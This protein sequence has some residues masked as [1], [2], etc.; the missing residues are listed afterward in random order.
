MKNLFTS[1]LLIAVLASCTKK[2]DVNLNICGAANP[3]QE[4]P[5]LA[6]FTTKMQNGDLGDCRRC[7]MYAEK[8]QN[9]DVLV[10]LNFPDN[11]VLCEV[12]ECNGTYS[13]FEN[14]E[15]LNQFMNKM[16]KERLVWK[17]KP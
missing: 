9:R 7:I 11:C 13:K 2:E 4:L 5:W 17:Y 12:R 3:V 16:K 1:I 6:E 8:Y 10:V 15:E 14:I